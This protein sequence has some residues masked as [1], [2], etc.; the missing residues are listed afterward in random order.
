MGILVSTDLKLWKE[1]SPFRPVIRKRN[2]P[3]RHTL[4]NPSVIK[5]G[6]TYHMYF[7]RCGKGRGIGHATS[8]NLTKWDNIT[9]LSFP[10]LPWAFGGPTA[11]VVLDLRETHGKWL[12]VYHGDRAK[13]HGGALGLAW[14]EDRIHWNV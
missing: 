11:P 8:K 1:A 9:Y 2:T 14:S 13:P 5:I 10:K 3:D 7:A 6:N 4:E 12:M